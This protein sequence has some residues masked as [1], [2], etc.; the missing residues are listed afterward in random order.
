MFYEDKFSV[1]SFFWLVVGGGEARS[2]S[3][4]LLWNREVAWAW[5]YCVRPCNNWSKS[6]LDVVCR[7]MLCNVYTVGS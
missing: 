2:L 6:G 1:L 5:S 4:S 3:V 7:A